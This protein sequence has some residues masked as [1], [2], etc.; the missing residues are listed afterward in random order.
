MRRGRQFCAWKSHTLTVSTMS[1]M[2]RLLSRMRVRSVADN[3]VAYARVSLWLPRLS[4][5]FSCVGFSFLLLFVL[6]ER[7]PG[8]SLG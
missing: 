4:A 7:R 8:A 1:A 6:L 3:H 5:R 2:S